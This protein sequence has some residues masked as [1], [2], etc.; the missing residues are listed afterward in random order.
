MNIL[1]G[2]MLHGFE[3]SGFYL[4]LVRQIKEQ[5]WKFL[6]VISF[7]QKGGGEHFGV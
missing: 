2:S 4:T 7:S 5:N 1:H 3:D 6:S